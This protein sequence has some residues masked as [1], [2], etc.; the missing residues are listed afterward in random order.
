MLLEYYMN[1]LQMTKGSV[2]QFRF[3]LDD[4]SFWL[5]QL[6]PVSPPNVL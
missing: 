3:F 4:P 5:T 1:A 2:N 6:I